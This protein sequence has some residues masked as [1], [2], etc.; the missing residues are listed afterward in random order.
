MPNA[1]K[2]YNHRLMFTEILLEQVR[3][4]LTG[5]PEVWAKE[6]GEVGNFGTTLGKV[7]KVS[8]IPF[9]KTKMPTD[10]RV[11]LRLHTNLCEVI[12]VL[13]F[14]IF[15]VQPTDYIFVLNRNIPRAACVKKAKGFK[16]IDK[17]ATELTEN[18]AD[19][20]FAQ[21]LMNFEEESILPDNPLTYLSWTYHMGKISVEVPYT[22]ALIPLGDGRTIFLYKRYYRP[23]LFSLKKSNFDIDQVWKV[24]KW[25]DKALG[26]FNYEGDPT[27]LEVPVPAASL[28]AIPEIAPLFEY[29]GRDIPFDID[30][31][32]YQQVVEPEPVVQQEAPAAEDQTPGRKFCT[33]C[34]TELPEDA[35]F[36]SKCGAKQT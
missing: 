31:S 15:A 28:L 14:R 18:G 5:I 22:M 21:H 1:Q 30:L 24:A 12:S 16:L 26:E 17:W 32:A 27:P 29:Q 11:F 7:A 8:L 25:I 36:C 19:D 35:A 2:L 23:G 9:A 20:P 10:C 33:K 3:P 6:F 34:G 4:Y 13:H